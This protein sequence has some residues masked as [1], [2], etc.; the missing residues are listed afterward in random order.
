MTHKNGQNK[1]TSFSNDLKNELNTL[2]S[3]KFQEEGHTLKEIKVFKEYLES[4]DEKLKD[5]YIKA[6]SE[7][8]GKYSL[9]DI[10]DNIADEILKINGKDVHGFKA[11]I[12][13]RQANHIYIDHGEKGK[14]DH[15]M[16]NEYDV[17]RL[18]FVIDNYDEISDAG[19]TDAYWEPKNNGKNRQAST[20]AFS[21]K[22]DGIYYVVIATPIT[23]AKELA[24]VTAYI[25]NKKRCHTAPEC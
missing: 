15:S 6:K 5:F 19:H 16:S 11:I 13:A 21:K 22:I 17:A 12:E 1:S 20:I 8:K 14:T 4:A 24:V 25:S 23:K 7:I 3:I 18:Q 10:K 2:T 9:N